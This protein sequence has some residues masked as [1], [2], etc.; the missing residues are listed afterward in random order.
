[1]NSLYIM[2]ALLH[3]SAIMSPGPD[4]TLIIGNTLSKGRA[5]GFQTV[6]GIVTGIA[7]FLLATLFGFTQ[8][9]YSNSLIFKVIAF[10]SGMY[11]MYIGIKII[12]PSYPQ[13]KSES[14]TFLKKFHHPYLQGMITNLLNPKALLYFIGLFSRKEFQN[15][16]WNIASILWIVS[17]IGFS[18]IVLLIS[19]EKIGNKLKAVLSKIEIGFGIFMI[20]FAFQILYFAFMMK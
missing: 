9:I 20:V 10:L 16:P 1:M 19:I 7:C 13:E 6:L 17:I 2:I 18:S 8:F 14:S 4:V 5:V 15:D 11:L 3:L 12:F